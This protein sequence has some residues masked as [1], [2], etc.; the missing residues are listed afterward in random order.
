MKSVGSSWAAAGALV[1]NRGL[2]ALPEPV[3]GDLFFDIEG[4]R[5][6][7]DDG[8][9]FGLQYL[10]GVID[11]GDV[12]ASGTPRYTQIWAFDRRDEK[13]AFEELV[14]FIMWRNVADRLGIDL[15]DQSVIDLFDEEIFSK[16]PLFFSQQFLGLIE[17]DLEKLANV[18][19][20]DATPS[21]S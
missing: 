8:K 1:P 6:Y 18:D 15:V 11:T 2:L 16:Q 19:R 4:A 20:H 7:S 10:F 3:A 12:P 13:R 17:E 5:Y 21:S 9:E 14:D